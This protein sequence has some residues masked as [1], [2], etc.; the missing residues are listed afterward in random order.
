MGEGKLWGED[1]R[2]RNG[3]AR[4]HFVGA[5]VKEG[6]AFI[7]VNIDAV[8]Q[9]HGLENEG[10]IGDGRILSADEI[11]RVSFISQSAA[12]S[13]ARALM[14]IECERVEDNFSS[15]NEHRP[16]S[17]GSRDAMIEGECC[18]ILEERDIARTED[19]ESSR[20]RQRALLFIEECVREEIEEEGDETVPLASA[21][22]L[23]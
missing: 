14:L 13:R 21:M 1:K 10:E 11:Q 2:I 22:E 12:R 18:R 3:T 9:F 19:E 15:H 7:P 5:T 20:S 23:V 16:G 4:A 6:A 17:D 8:L